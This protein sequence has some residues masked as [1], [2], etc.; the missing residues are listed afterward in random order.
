MEQLESQF[1]P[2]PSSLPMMPR[3]WP[4]WLNLIITTWRPITCQPSTKRRN[5]LFIAVDDMRP[6]LG[7]YNFSLA[8]TPNM[9]RLASEGVTFKRAYVQSTARYD[10]GVDIFQLVPRPCHRQRAPKG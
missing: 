4:L 2:D 8:H 1:G 5:V 9:D 7:A 6:T 3:F 10:S